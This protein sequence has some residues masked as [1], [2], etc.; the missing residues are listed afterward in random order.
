VLNN[1]YNEGEAPVIRD[2]SY[3]INFDLPSAY[4]RYKETSSM[5][6]KTDGAVINLVST[7]PGNN[8]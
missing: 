6:E 1:G 7:L 5:I 2:V 3:V 4:S 8:S